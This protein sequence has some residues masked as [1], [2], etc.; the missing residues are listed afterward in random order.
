[1]WR[2]API[3]WRIVPPSRSGDPEVPLIAV[4]TGTIRAFYLGAIARRSTFDPA[5]GR[6]TIRREE[7]RS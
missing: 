1:M 7:I 6:E 2:F 3:S 5:N 4:R